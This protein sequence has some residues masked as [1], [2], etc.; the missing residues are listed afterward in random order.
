MHWA[1][2]DPQNG[3]GQAGGK[4]LKPFSCTLNHHRTGSSSGL[5]IKLIL[6]TVAVP[7]AAYC[8]VGSVNISGLSDYNATAADIVRERCPIHLV[9]VA[10]VSGHD[11]ADVLF[12]W[13][14]A[15]IK[16]RLAALL[17]L[18]GFSVGF[19]ISQ[20]WRRRKIGAFR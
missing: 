19:F 17:V 13:C 20:N 1:E 2:R 6:V 7:V 5:L 15:E 11:Q 12:N 10:W 18:W 16:A 14:F 3:T 4:G 9:P 8:L